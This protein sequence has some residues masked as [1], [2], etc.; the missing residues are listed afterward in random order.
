MS[1]RIRKSVAGMDGYTPGEQPRDRRIVKLNTNENPYPPSPRVEQALKDISPEDMRRYPEPV[2]R[3]LRDTIAGLH[4][5]TPQQVFVGNGS[6]EILALCTRA[7]VENDGTIGYFDPSYSLYPV[8]AEIR[9]VSTCAVPL[10]E[11]FEWPLDVDALP[12]EV[13][14]C[15]LFL[16]TVPNAP[17]GNSYP[18]ERVQGFCASM[19]GVVVLDEAYV[20]FAD[21]DFMDLATAAENVLVARTLSKAYSLA[22]VR[23]G[24]AVGHASL[25]EALDKIKDSYNVNVLSQTAALAALRDPAHMRQNATRIKTTRGRLGDALADL[26]FTVYPSQANFL[27]VRPARLAAAEVYARLHE[28]GVLV[29]HFSD[30]RTRDFLRITV[31]TDAEVDQLLAA[32]RDSGL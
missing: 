22:G 2:S 21:S 25:I 28:R 32:C 3:E 16:V 24:Y 18:R 15:S 29:R 31:G 11:S 4:G 27:W 17:T 30:E 14:A 13:E 6:D 7:F 9:D 12:A 26:G 10:G 23:T 20:D 8:L 19:P 1:D 5:C